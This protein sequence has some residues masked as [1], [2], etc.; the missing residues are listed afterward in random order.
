MLLSAVG[1]FPEV[2]ERGAAR[3]AAPGDTASLRA[4]LVALLDDEPARR[5]LSGAALR[6]AEEHSWER[7]AARTHELYVR[8]CEEAAR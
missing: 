8:L 7:V 1:G 6:L 2:A 4:E 5:A 3:L